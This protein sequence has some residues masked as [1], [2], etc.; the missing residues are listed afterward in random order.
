M[1]P[2][3]F[4]PPGI[5]YIQSTYNG[6]YATVR[7]GGVGALEV[8]GSIVAD[9]D[10]EWTLKHATD[11]NNGRYTIT[12]ALHAKLP[13]GVDEIEQNAAVQA[14][15]AD[16]PQTWI[17]E[18]RDDEGSFSI[19]QVD[20]EINYVWNVQQDSIVIRGD[21]GHKVQSWTFVLV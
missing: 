11:E 4:P 13:L 12:A 8:Y 1:T 3:D 6:G 21:D 5:Y 18:K 16:P 17:L 19:G 2:S 15:K 7:S 9:Y 20:S 14:K 10:Q